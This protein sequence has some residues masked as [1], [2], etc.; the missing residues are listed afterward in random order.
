M[1]ASTP[2]TVRALRET[3]QRRPGPTDLRIDLIGTGP[4]LLALDPRFRITT[5]PALMGELKALFGP[6]CLR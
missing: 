6:G 1:G 2:H 4:R 3:L 5:S